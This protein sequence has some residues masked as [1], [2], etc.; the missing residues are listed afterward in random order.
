MERAAGE[1]LLLEE[2][3][4]MDLADGC[5]VAAPVARGAV[6]PAGLLPGELRGGNA[7]R[8]RH[9]AGAVSLSEQE[10]EI[11]RQLAS[12]RMVSG[13]QRWQLTATSC[14]LP[15]TSYHS[16]VSKKWLVISG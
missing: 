10:R 13:D 8:W 15:A 4:L 14:Q 3:P 5:A 11:A 2:Q 9:G 12:A 6:R 7:R 1:A 16:V